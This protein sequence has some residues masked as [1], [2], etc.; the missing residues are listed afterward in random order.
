MEGVS[1]V[2][3]LPRVGVPWRRLGAVGAGRGLVGLRN[4]D[5][6]GRECLWDGEM[7]LQMALREGVREGSGA[8]AR[9]ALGRP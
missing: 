9:G 6:G 4:G 7:G 5:T 8:G 2:R 1:G 3:E